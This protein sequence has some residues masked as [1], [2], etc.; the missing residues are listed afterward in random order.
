MEKNNLYLK[1]KIKL[2]TI[3]KVAI[4]NYKKQKNNKKIIMNRKLS[5]SNRRKKKSKR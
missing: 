1:M 5:N 4:K 2:Q 3:K